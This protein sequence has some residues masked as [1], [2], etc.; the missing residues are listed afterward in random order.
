[1]DDLEKRNP[2][3]SWRKTFRNIKRLLGYITP[4]WQ[5]KVTIGLIIISTLLEIISPSIIGGVIDLVSSVKS[6]GSVPKVEG[7]EA[8]IYNIFTPLAY[9]L[10][11]IFRVDVT[12]ALL[13]VL[14]VAIVSVAS[15]IGVLNYLQRYLL[16]YVSQKGSFEIRNDLYNSLLEQ[17][18]SF[19][20]RERTGQLM[21]RVTGDVDEIQRFFGFGLNQVIASTL[22][23]ALVFLSMFS[24]EVRLTLITLIFLPM[25]LYTTFKF[26]SEI[27]IIIAKIRNQFGVL[28]S[29]VQE[30]LMGVRVV[31]GFARERYEEEKFRKECE[32]YFSINIEAVKKRA[33]YL[34]LATFISSLSV[35][36][37]I[38]YGG[39]QVIS[40]ALTIGSLVAFYY[41]VARLTGPVRMV[42]FITAMFQR[43]TA[44]ADRIFEVM[45]ARQDIEDKEGALELESVE[46]KIIFKNVWFSYDGKNMVLKNINLEAKPG[47]T[48]AILGAAGSGKSSIINLIPRFYDVTHGSIT[49]DG[50]DIRDVAVESLR[51]HIGTVRQ[52]PFIFS[53]TIKENIA[54]GIENA[55]QEDIEAAAKRAQIHDFI[56]SLPKGYD[57]MVGERGVTLS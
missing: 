46:G 25:I 57:T 4:Y 1:M 14:S 52:D 11:S 17:S 39:S 28:T 2:K 18:F 29:E 54:Y 20:D 30:N 37:I 40:R 5:L 47:D 21:A 33:F 42:G 9:S 19:Y 34:P 3:M 36:F 16:A 48:V 51:R 12:F 35:V 43:A 56:A 24:I 26:A 13:G 7:L 15:L 44:A 53:K 23:F 22:L 27:G 10:S 49:I 6:G 32:K 55:R 41:Y 50:I 38:L 8:F 31:R 45:D